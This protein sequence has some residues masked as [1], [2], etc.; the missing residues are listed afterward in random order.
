M[1]PKQFLAIG[2]VVLVILGILGV[3]LADA[4]LAGGLFWLTTGENVAHI[5]LGIVA[6]AAVSVPGIS[7]ALAPYY[8]P[9][10]VLVGIVSLF[11]GIYG[12]AV[13]GIPPLNTFGLANLE[14][15]ID[16]ALHLAVGAWAMY[17]AFAGA[18]MPAG[19]PQAMA[20]HP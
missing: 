4:Q 9:I 3:G 5:V 17:A 11:F 1:N 2:G 7:T 16:N 12:F 19:R 10:V 6:L 18:R 8:R 20:S 13:A 14:N 15:P